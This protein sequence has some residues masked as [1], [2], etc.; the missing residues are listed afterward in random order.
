VQ[1]KLITMS[2]E[3]AKWSDLHAKQIDLM[4]KIFDNAVIKIIGEVNG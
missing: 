1:E 3:F 2:A 4:T